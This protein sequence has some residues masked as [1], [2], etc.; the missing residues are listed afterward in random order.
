M[1][2]RDSLQHPAKLIQMEKKKKKEQAEQTGIAVG[3]GGGH[4]HVACY[5][6]DQS[7]C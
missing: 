6:G 1:S 4:V 2:L 5:H 3:G 7:Y